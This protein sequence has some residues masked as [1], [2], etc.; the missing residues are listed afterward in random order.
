MAEK[1]AADWEESK[2]FLAPVT[3]N[4]QEPMRSLAG[5]LSAQHCGASGGNH[6]PVQ[7]SEGASIGCEPVWNLAIIVCFEHS[8]IPFLPRLN[9]AFP[10]AKPQS[11]C[12]ID[13]SSRDCFRRRHFHMCASQGQYEWH[14]GCRGRTWIG[15]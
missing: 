10:I 11:P 8:A 1:L 13:G 6:R 3:E 4:G 12:A 15:V 5:A 14:A 9:R 2:L 7:D